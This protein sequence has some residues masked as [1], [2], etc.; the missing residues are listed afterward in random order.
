MA[1]RV[2]TCPSPPLAAWLRAVVAGAASWACDLYHHRGPRAQKSPTLALMSWGHHLEILQNAEQEL[3]LSF[4]TG[5]HG[6]GGQVLMTGPAQE[7]PCSGSPEGA[8]SSCLTEG[9][10]STGT[11]LRL[12]LWVGGVGVV[13]SAAQDCLV[14]KPSTPDPWMIS[15]ARPSCTCL[16]G[17]PLL[18]FRMT[19]L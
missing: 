17:R 18:P 6:L 7:V 19:R 9:T 1:W 2:L 10:R 15:L 16:R 14:I 13:G 12:E 8:G 3:V 4:Y 11:S 5:S